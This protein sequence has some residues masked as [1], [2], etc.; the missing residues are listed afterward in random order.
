MGN[1][2]CMLSRLGLPSSQKGPREA[3]TSFVVLGLFLYCRYESGRTGEGIL[4]VSG[5]KVKEARIPMRA[6]LR[7]PGSRCTGGQ[8]SLD[9]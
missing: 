8:R 3:G 7:L 9:H 1:I 4:G 5:Q 6:S 2:Q